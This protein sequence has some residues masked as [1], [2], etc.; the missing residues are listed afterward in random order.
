VFGLIRASTVYTKSYSFL[1]EVQ[2][3]E[4]HTELCSEVRVIFARA[5]Y[6]Q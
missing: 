5:T 1:V 3:K 6:K 2:T 4:P